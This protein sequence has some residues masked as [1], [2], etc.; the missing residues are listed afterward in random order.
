MSDPV[1]EVATLLGKSQRVLFITGAGLSADSG[2]PT[3]RGI[4]GLYDGDAAR[5]AGVPIEEALS[6]SMLRRDP[7][8]C[9]RH[10]A[11]IEAACRGARANEGHAVI[12][13]LEQRLPHDKPREQQRDK[14]Q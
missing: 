2:L 14:Q 11:R 12:A 10:I 5:E 13:R 8:L 1:P 9:W 6:G 3:Y 4:G 7:A